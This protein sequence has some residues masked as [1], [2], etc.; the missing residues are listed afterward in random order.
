MPDRLRRPFDLLT[1]PRMASPGA[2]ESA[3]SRAPARL[4]YNPSADLAELAA[5]D[6]FA[7]ATSHPFTD[8]NKRTAFMCMFT[9]LGLN[10]LRIVA[11]EMEVV[12]LMM[13]VAAGGT[14]EPGLAEWLR[15]NTGIR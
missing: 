14:D 4:N 1:E 8:G 3:L 12:P 5:C 9:F 6:G 2:L 13:G 10:G 15:N 7:I 11:P